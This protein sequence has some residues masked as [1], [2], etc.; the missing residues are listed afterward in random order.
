[1]RDRRGI[2]IQKSE[3]RARKERE[4]RVTNGR[5]KRKRKKGKSHA[6]EDRNGTKGVMRMKGEST[7]AVKT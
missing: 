5:Q 3:T 7:A 2:D 1:M 6:S 4:E